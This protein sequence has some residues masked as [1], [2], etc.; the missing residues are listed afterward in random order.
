V[1]DLVEQEDGRE[2]VVNLS[3]GVELHGDKWLSD[4]EQDECNGE[5]PNL[6]VFKCIDAR[7]NEIAFEDII[8]DIE[9]VEQQ[10]YYLVRDIHLLVRGQVHESIVEEHRIENVV[11][12]G[13]GDVDTAKRRL[14]YCCCTTEREGGKLEGLSLYE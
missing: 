12:Y 13:K 3:E 7:A 2:Y 9:E 14:G 5:V 1:V 8:C 4:H 6:E 10:L 11:E